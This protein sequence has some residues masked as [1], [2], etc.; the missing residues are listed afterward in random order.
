MAVIEGMLLSDTELREN[1]VEFVFGGYFAGY[2][3]KVV[4][5]AADVEGDEVAGDVVVEAGFD[6]VKGG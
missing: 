6:E 1:V 3:A 2:F 5:A 4:E